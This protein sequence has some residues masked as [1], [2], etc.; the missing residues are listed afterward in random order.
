MVQIV[1]FEFYHF[2]YVHTLVVHFETKNPLLCINAKM[3]LVNETKMHKGKNARKKSMIR[4]ARPRKKNPCMV[5]L[6]Y[7]LQVT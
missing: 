6:I 4:N 3:C 5:F 2:T 7:K 1:E